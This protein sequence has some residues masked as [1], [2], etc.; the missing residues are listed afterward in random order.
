M[1]DVSSKTLSLH[2]TLLNDLDQLLSVY[3]EAAQELIDWVKHDGYFDSIDS[4]LLTW[5]PSCTSSGPINANGLE[6]RAKL[7]D[8]VYRDVPRIRNQRLADAYGPFNFLRP[9]YHKS[10]R[11]YLQLREQFVSRAA[12]STQEFLQFYQSLYIKVL[13]KGNLF[14]PEAGEAALEQLKI[15]R[16]P[17]MQ[18]QSTAEGLSGLVLEDD[19]RWEEVYSYNLDGKI[20]QDT[21]RNLLLDIAQRSLDFI[22]ASGLLATRFNYLNN[23]ALFG[24]SVWKVIVDADLLYYRLN[25]ETCIKKKELESLFSDLNLAKG[26]IVEFLH[27]HQEDPAKLR[28]ESY[29]YGQEY[30]Y[31]TRDMIDLTVKIQGRSNYLIQKFGCPKGLKKI[32]LPPLLSGKIK[33]RFLEYPSVGKKGIF[34]PLD[35][36]VRISRWTIASWVLGWQKRRLARSGLDE[37]DRFVQAWQ[38][39][40]VWGKAVLSSFNIRLKIWVDPQF[41]QIARELDLGSGKKKIIFLPTHQSLLDHSVM[42]CVLNSPEILT[43]LGWKTS[44]PCA[45]LARTGLTRA[46]SIQVGSKNLTIFGMSSERFDGLLEAVDGYITLERS[47]ASGHTT[48]KM[49]E[50]IGKRPGLIYPMGTTAAFS[51]QSF[52]LQQA[53]FAQL[54]QD[55]V[56]I[57]IALRG[58]HS[59]WPKCPKGNLNINPGL[60]EVIVSPPILG[61]TALMPKR[62]SLRIQTEAANLVQAMQISTLLNPEPRE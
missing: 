3:D 49:V 42:Y 37:S 58:L 32:V 45:I 13:A 1:A 24:S 19:A 60:V 59:L 4:N 18:A 15:T 6:H 62:R 56:L 12:G 50:T 54:P 23:F 5:P 41:K 57:P 34:S 30:S 40:L 14:S 28:P 16:I 17:L 33:D 26:M 31:L 52:P 25:K 27:A 2:L 61:E 9:A 43:A 39:C 47:G 44:V 35:R 55:V 48:S 20:A 8:A 22:A 53:V 10:N 7:V 38:N 21:L 36:L 11:I 51:N 29:W 46:A